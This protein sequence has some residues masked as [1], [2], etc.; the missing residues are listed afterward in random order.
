[1]GC[2]K[3]EAAQT[4]IQPD[5]WKISGG[6]VAL[7][8]VEIRRKAKAITNNHHRRREEELLHH[9][10]SLSLP[11]ITPS[12]QVVN[13]TQLL[14]RH[15]SLF[16]LISDPSGLADSIDSNFQQLDRTGQELA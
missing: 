12:P 16:F 14:K 3:F 1:L 11:C 4:K 2:L 8:E 9:K 13:T 6:D 15:L 5:F 7:S 10:S